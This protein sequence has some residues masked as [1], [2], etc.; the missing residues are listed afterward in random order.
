MKKILAAAILTVITFM[1]FTYTCSGG[2]SAKLDEGKK[3]FKRHCEICHPGGGNIVNKAKTLHK[4]DL[5]ANGIKAPEDVVRIMRNPGPGMMKFDEK[6]IPDRDAREIA[7][8]VI[9]AFN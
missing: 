2:Q 3:L 4:K 9:T 5:D 1:F 7:S 6:T 8:Y